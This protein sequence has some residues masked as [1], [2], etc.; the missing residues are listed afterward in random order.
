[1]KKNNF[2]L[3]ILITICLLF[4]SFEIYKFNQACWQGDYWEHQ[5]VVKELI[6]N[7]SQPQ[8]PIFKTS[9]PH[10]FFSPYSFLVA[11]TGKIMQW[12][13]AQSLHF[14]AIFNTILF[15]LSIVFFCKKT[16]PNYFLNMS[17]WSIIL[18]LFFWGYQPT[19]WS[20][21]Y[22]FF[23]FH[24]VAPYPSTFSIII[25]LFLLGFYYSN[26]KNNLSAFVFPILLNAIVWITHPTTAIFLNLGIGLIFISKVN[27]N[28]SILKQ[29]LFFI[30]PTI[31]API[32]L[33]ILWPYYPFLE[34]F[35]SNNTDFQ[36]DSSYLY[37]NLFKKYWIIIPSIFYFYFF[38]KDVFV[39]FLFLFSITIVA[40][41]I[42]S[43]NINLP[44]FSRLLSNLTMLIQFLFAYLLSKKINVETN[45]Q[46]VIYYSKIV[47]LFI[48]FSLNWIFWKET[49][50]S[51]NLDVKYYTQYYFLKKQIKPTDLIF[52]DANANYFIP[53]I[54]GKIFATN[55]PIYWIDDLAKRRKNINDFYDLNSTDSLRMEIIKNCNANYLLINKN[56]NGFSN[57]SI[58]KFKTLGKTTFYSNFLLIKLKN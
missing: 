48:A 40:I 22:N 39:Q 11:G 31:I 2:S 46:A 51:K 34:L 33:A 26:I 13:A 10:A 55:R 24:L 44:G 53:A 23:S 1:M 43:K 6:L 3:G 45:K 49:I 29:E 56:T 4:I 9:T 52:A 19:D 50:F 47:I 54:E 17:S 32:L 27:N 7:F 21:F 42:I 5:A 35:T 12:N 18:I 37:Q 15:I 41:L 30:L 25:T 36:N 8:N 38:R 57:T 28:T 58:D 16:S 20:G 14:F